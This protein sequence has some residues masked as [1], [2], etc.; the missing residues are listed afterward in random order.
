MRFTTTVY[1]SPD[2]V[3]LTGIEV[4]AEVVEKLGSKRP[5]V[6]ISVNGFTYRSSVASM[7]GR[8]LVGLSKER[9]E[10]A[11]VVGGDEVEVDIEVDTAP[12]VFEL[13]EAGETALAGEPGAADAW[14]RLSYSAQQKL[15]LPVVNAK[16][17]ATRDRNLEKLLAALRG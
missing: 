10:A 2:N 6:V 4:P 15:G 17:D 13:G 8:Y 7:G 11:G 9:R 12:R 1:V 5:Q 14:S 16:T 3:N